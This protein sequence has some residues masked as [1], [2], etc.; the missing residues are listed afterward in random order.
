MIKVI[1]EDRFFRVEHNDEV[2]RVARTAER[3]PPSDAQHAYETALGKVPGGAR[4]FLDLRE[5]SDDG[6]VVERLASRLAGF[7]R[8]AVLTKGRV[9]IP[10]VSVFDDEDHAFDHLLG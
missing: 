2:H 5:G 9:Q 3:L 7:A 6:T 10:G 1:H 8:V 4:V